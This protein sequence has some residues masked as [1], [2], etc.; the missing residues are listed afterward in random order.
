MRKLLLFLSLILLVGCSSEDLAPRIVISNTANAYIVGAS[1]GETVEFEFTSSTSWVLTEVPKELSVSANSGGKG[2][3]KIVVKTKVAN[4]TEVIIKYSLKISSSYGEKQDEKIII[5]EQLPKS[6]LSLSPSINQLIGF[7]AGEEFHLSFSCAASWSVTDVP[8]GIKLSVTSGDEGD[9]EVVVSTTHVNNSNETK[10]YT[11]TIKSEY[12][13]V[14]E[15][16][17]VT[18]EQL[19]AFT[20]EQTIYK[21]DSE[22]GKINVVFTYNGNETYSG[23]NLPPLALLYDTEEGPRMIGDDTDTNSAPELGKTRSIK[24][25]WSIPVR[26]N[27]SKE[28]RSCSLWIALMDPKNQDSMDGVVA[29]TTE[30]VFVQTGTDYED[31]DVDYTNDGKVSTLQTHTKGQG[32]PVVLTG[33]GFLDTHIAAGTFDDV[34]KMA[35]KYLFSVEPMKSLKDYFDVYSVTAVSKESHFTAHSETAFNLRFSSETTEIT[36]DRDRIMSYVQKVDGLSTDSSDKTGYFKYYNTL[37]IVIANVDRY[38]GTCE[39]HLSSPLSGVSTGY[40]VAYVP[41]AVAKNHQGIGMEH[42]LHHEAIGHGFGKLDDEYSYVESGRITDE[43][44]KDL[45]K[46]YELRAYLNTDVKSDVKQTH[47]A[48]LAADTHYGAEALGAYEGA[49]TFYKGV[50]RPTR[51]S[52]MDDNTGGFNA[53]SREL[54]YKRAMMIANGGEFTYKYE[55]FQSFDKPVWSTYVSTRSVSPWQESKRLSLPPLARPRVIYE[56]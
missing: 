56:D 50:Y 38:A 21:I 1:V 18:V 31:R 26:K 16:V 28:T 33:D 44:L 34:M 17:D 42:L 37:V 45:E 36:G 49:H 22:G 32:I 29:T 51:T 5:V 52:I 9:N 12:G 4:N 35:Y 24:L 48:H 2:K 43:E 54:I 46:K 20:L 23:S 40:S 14:K 7:R 53:P 41:M 10:K 25:V 13:N 19:S 27:T 8:D 6:L 15:E 11:F 39:V 47:W 55:D 3:N 30:F